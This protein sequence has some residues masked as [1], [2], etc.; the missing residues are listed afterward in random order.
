MSQSTEPVVIHAVFVKSYSKCAAV[1]VNYN[2]HTVKVIFSIII[3]CSF[4]KLR[5][6]SCPHVPPNLAMFSNQCFLSIPKRP[7]CQTVNTGLITL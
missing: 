6:I 7:V 5:I 3:L 1:K 4:S 2:T